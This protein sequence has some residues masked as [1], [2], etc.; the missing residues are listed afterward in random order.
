MASIVA[1][2]AMASGF[3]CTLERVHM[4]PLSTPPVGSSML[5]SELRARASEG[6]G[7]RLSWDLSFSTT[8]Q[9][10]INLDVMVPGPPSLISKGY[11][12]LNDYG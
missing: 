7:I 5:M 12:T 8:E 2:R 9:A 10:S 11:G 4:S 6:E 3:K 1:I